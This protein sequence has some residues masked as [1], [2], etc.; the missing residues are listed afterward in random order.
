MKQKYYYS[1]IKADNRRFY[2]LNFLYAKLY[3]NKVRKISKEDKEKEITV[4]E[5][6]AIHE[7]S[8]FITRRLHKK[9]SSII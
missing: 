4:K 1:K 9:I 2:S 5:Y 6:S 3:D 8:N 7:T